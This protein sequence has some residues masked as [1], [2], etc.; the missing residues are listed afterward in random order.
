MTKTRVVVGGTQGEMLSVYP[1]L[2]KRYN[3]VDEIIIAGEEGIGLQT[4][5]DSKLSEYADGIVEKPRVR[6]ILGNYSDP[7]VCRGFTGRGL[8]FIEN[9]TIEDGILFI[10]GGLSEDH[11]IRTDMVDWWEQEESTSDEWEKLLA[12]L[13]K[14]GVRDIHTLVSHSVPHSLLKHISDNGLPSRTGMYLD[15]L[16]QRLPSLR[17]NISGHYRKR[18]EVKL[19]GVRY[20]GLPVTNQL[21][22]HIHEII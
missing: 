16:V 3:H 8:S 5:N 18:F 17:L 11:S 14:R 15:I 20:V 1:S 22:E 9:G 10:G 13:K 12:R 4:L 6:F 2:R 21:T 7:Y 19:N